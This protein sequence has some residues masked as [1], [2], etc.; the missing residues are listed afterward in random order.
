[1]SPTEEAAAAPET[2]VRWSEALSRLLEP[3]VFGPIVGAIAVIIGLVVIHEISGRIHFDDIHAALTGTPL[4]AILTALLLTGV[5]FCAL[6]LY[7]VL[8]VRRVAAGKVLMR[9]AAFAGFVGYGFSNALGFHVFVGG[10][11]RYRIYQASGLDASDVGR[12][13]GISLLT[14]SG[15]LMTIVG[16]ALVL[17]PIGV[18]ALH[19]ISPFADRIIGA[20]VLAVIAG[21]ILW[22]SRGNTEVS[23]LG[24][25]FPLPSARSAVLQIL[26][27]AVDIGASAA[28]LYILMPADVAPGYAAFLLIFVAAIIASIIS[29]APG[30]IGVLEATILLGLGAGM[31]PDVIAAL[32]LFRVIYYFVPL[33]LAAV[34]LV[35]FEAFRAR[36]TLKTASARGAAIAR[37][38]VPP[39]AATLTFVGGLVLLFS[40]ATPTLADRAAALRSIIPL[41][42]AETSHLLASLTGLLLIVIS[43][44]LYRRIALARLLAIGLLLAG[45]AFSL[46]KGLDWEEALILAALAGLISAN[47]SA[48]YRKGNWRSFRPTPAW[49]GLIIVVIVAATVVGLFA[50]RHVEYREALWWRFSWDNDAPRFLRASLALAIVAAAVAVDA[51]INRPAQPRSGKVAIPAP[52]RTIL[53]TSAGTQPCVALLGDKNFLVSADEKAFIMYGVYGR[54]WITMGDPA[55]DED[56]ARSLI[57]RFAETADRAGG[58]AVFYAVQPQFLPTYLDLGLAI[59]KIGEVARVD[60]DGFSLAGAARQPFR[61][62]ESRARREGIAFSVV[63]K[64]EVRALLPDLRA[65]SDAWMQGKS[66]HEKGFS[67]GR[68]EDDYV[69][70]FD[71]AVMRKDGRIVAFANLWRSGDRDELSVDMM[72]YVPGVSHVLM[73]ALF[74]NLML[75]ASAESYRWFSLGAAPL[76][77]LSN[78]PLASTWNR[79]GTF[80][81]RRGDEFYNFEGLRAFKQKFDP[82]WTPQYIACRGGLAMPQ[83]LLDVTSLISGSPIGAL[84]K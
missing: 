24:W 27:G 42:F 61:Y 33:L 69:A 55:G 18:P 50:Y 71:C 63:S 21:A 82:V 43:R 41:P 45:A 19:I 15:G 22:L 14:F 58:R 77:G 68:F 78:H 62:A 80:I 34:S 64:Q 2:G 74:A 3:R 12:I 47:N 67:I 83:I 28:A 5:S 65:V 53:E 49:I 4:S 66:G 39:T 16:V 40:G 81:Y 10:P 56:A 54:S 9:I 1:M 73:D 72:R 37:V 36:A 6:S 52:V 20:L 46:L 48:F 51:L 35:A 70:E 38:V 60:L 29:H 59:L 13:V 79:I 8:A 76:S 75:Y 25:R 57:W 31:R 26:V 84:R 17:D 30:G 7:D 32:L 44:G 11:I 23:L